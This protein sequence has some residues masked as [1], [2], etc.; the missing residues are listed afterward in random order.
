M[1]IELDFQDPIDSHDLGKEDVPME[2]GSTNSED[3]KPD[4]MDKLNGILSR[5][6]PEPG[7]EF[8]A[9]MDGEFGRRSS[10][11]RENRK[12]S[13]DLTAHSPRRGRSKSPALQDSTYAS[14]RSRTP[15]GGASVRRNR[16]QHPLPAKPDSSLDTSTKSPPKA[17]EVSA[18]PSTDY[19]PMKIKEEKA[20]SRSRSAS[21]ARRDKEDDRRR[22]RDY[23]TQPVD[24][25][26]DKW[27]GAKDNKK[28]RTSGANG[29]PAVF[30]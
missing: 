25:S 23:N 12:E 11:K 24:E 17:L 26:Q 7:S 14:Y 1:L 2:L 18:N 4:V 5:Q 20:R 15:S 8:R 21:P 10:I 3:G 16:T 29:I 9:P 30:G 27:K 19:A 28:R 13:R 22:H 6:S